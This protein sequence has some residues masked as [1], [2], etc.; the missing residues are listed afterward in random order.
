MNWLTIALGVLMIAF[1]IAT[2]IVRRTRPQ[3]FAKLEPMKQRWGE[4]AGF[5]LH[6]LGYSVVPIISGLSFAI[7][8]AY[9]VAVF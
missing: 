2:S 6:V 8:G 7:A 3:L 5:W 1:G 9:G 4:R